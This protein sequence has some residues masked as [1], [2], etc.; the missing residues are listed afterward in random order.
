[1]DLTTTGIAVLA[2]VTL[3]MGFSKGGVAGLVLIVV[4]LLS[5]VMDVKQAVAVSLPLLLVGDAF[6][7]YAYW[8]QWENRA[9]WLLIPG[10][11]VG[12]VVG[13]YI[14]AEINEALLRR[15][16]GGVTLL[17]VTY[18]LLGGRLARLQMDPPDW[19]GVI[20][21]L[22][23]G[24]ASALAASGSPFF[25]AYYLLKRRPPNI[26]MGTFTVFFTV[27]NVVKLPLY[28]QQELLSWRQIAGVLPYIPLIPLGVWLGK[29]FLARLS[30]ETFEQVILAVLTFTG[31]YFLLG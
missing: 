25:I 29:L 24:I 21:S 14:L 22:F 10:V 20:A 19:A 28:I 31:F 18:R 16:I 8:R 5:T 26:F 13:A 15:A 2:V 7:V 11:V 17:Y 12:T 6:T 23:A 9:L 27:S 1:M 30:V 4:P 3:L